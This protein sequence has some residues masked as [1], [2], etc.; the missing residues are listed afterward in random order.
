VELLI[1]HGERDGFRHYLFGGESAVLTALR[2]ARVCVPEA[3]ACRGGVP[4]FRA[5]E[6]GEMEEAGRGSLRS[7]HSSCGSGSDPQAGSGGRKA[8]R[9]GCCSGYPV[10][11]RPRSISW[12]EPSDGPA[13]LG[14]AV[15][16]VG[17]SGSTRLGSEALVRLGTS[18]LI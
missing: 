18:S 6:D 10:R 13:G 8:E 14:S 4:P 7:I 15:Q 3:R 17:S 2:P 9:P 5:M 12:P 16:A 1:R 11:R